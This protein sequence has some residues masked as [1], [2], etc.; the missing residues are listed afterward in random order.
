MVFY[1]VTHNKVKKNKTSSFHVLYDKLLGEWVPRELGPSEVKNLGDQLETVSSYKK[2][3]VIMEL[4]KVC[5][6]YDNS[7]IF[8]NL[9]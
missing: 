9:I 7:S 6:S 2:N 1:V 5:Q 4:K 3:F 8:K